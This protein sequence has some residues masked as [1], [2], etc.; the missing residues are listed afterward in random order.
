M[1][2]ALCCAY[3]SV[4]RQILVTKKQNGIR[5]LRLFQSLKHTD[6]INR[7]LA[8]LHNINA[9]SI[10]LGNING[11]KYHYHINKRNVMHFYHKGSFWKNRSHD[12]RYILYPSSNMT[13]SPS[14]KSKAVNIDTHSTPPQ[15]YHNYLYQ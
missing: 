12:I 10:Q 14:Y 1:H 15:C 3:V 8:I 5:I 7:M 4:R 9:S 11:S 2:S 13:E 6:I